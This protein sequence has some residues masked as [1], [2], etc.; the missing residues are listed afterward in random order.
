MRWPD[1]VVAFTHVH[2]PLPENCFSPAIYL[3]H[4]R[5]FDAIASSFSIN[6]ALRRIAFSAAI[7]RPCGRSSLLMTLMRPSISD[8]YAPEVLKSDSA[9]GASEASSFCWPPLR[10]TELA[11]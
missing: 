5:C 3:Q 8:G 7:R 2:F 9:S 6:V 1:L 10:L 4:F 11:A